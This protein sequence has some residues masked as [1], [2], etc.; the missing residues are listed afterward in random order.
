[1][2]S[3]VRQREGLIRV[4]EKRKKVKRQESKPDK[5]LSG[6]HKLGHVRPLYWRFEGAIVVLRE[7]HRA[8]SCAVIGT[9]GPLCGEDEGEDGDDECATLHSIP[10]CLVRLSR[11]DGHAPDLCV[12]QCHRA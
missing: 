8:R 5:E 7:C 12:E 6:D 2:W 10:W 1:M 9:D 11:T 3:L 4:M